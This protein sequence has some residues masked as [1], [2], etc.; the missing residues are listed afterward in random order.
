MY[1]I[2]VN[3]WND[4]EVKEPD[5]AAK[6]VKIPLPMAQRMKKEVKKK[7]LER[8]HPSVSLRVSVISEKEF[9]R[10]AEVGGGPGATF[11]ERAGIEGETW[12]DTRNWYF[13]LG[14]SS[15]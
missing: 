5:N 11:V 7:I 10:G 3:I 1:I 2:I 13:G 15:G 6:R 14:V 4:V 9:L 8:C 12:N